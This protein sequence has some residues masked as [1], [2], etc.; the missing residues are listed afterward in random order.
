MASIISS[1]S[2]LIS[3]VPGLK[4]SADTSGALQI[5][6]GNNATAITVDAS[7]NV[8]IGTATPTAK[9]HVT[10]SGV[11]SVP[12][13]SGTT[14]ATGTLI[15]LGTSSDSAGG[16]GTI[17]LSTNQMWIQVTDSTNLAAGNALLL[18]PNGGNV[19]IGISSPTGKLDISATTDGQLMTQVRNLSNGTSAYSAFFMGNDTNATAAYIGLNSSNNTARGGGA[20]S[21]NIINGL[22]GPV[23]FG[24][25][26]TERMRIDSSG[27]VILGYDQATGTQVVKS[28]ATA[29]AVGN[30][31]GEVR[32]GINDGSFGGI[33]IPDVTSTNASY[34]A[35]YIQFHTHQGGVSAG[36]RMRITA[37]GYVGIAT[38]APAAL[39][40][41][42][43]LS[44]GAINGYTKFIIDSSDY[45]VATLKSPA[46]NFSQIIFTDTTTTSLG[47]INYFNSTNATPNA[48]AF[49]TA[50]S[51][52]MRIDSSG[53]V[54]IG[55]FTT[56]IA[57]KFT[58]IGEGNF[59]D[60]SNNTRLYIG[61]GTI[62]GT[63]GGGAYIYNADNTPLAFG[64][65]NTERMRIDTSGNVGIGTTVNN[66]YDQVAAQ[67]PLVVQRS[68]TSTTLNGSTAAIAIVNGDTTTSN[69]AQLN[70]AAITGA[71]TNQ[72]SSAIIACTFGAR[73]NGQYPTGILTFSTSTSLNAAP[74]EKM[75]IESSG[76][77]GI[78]TSSPSASAI[79]DAQSTTK[80]VR[81]PNMTT[82]QKNAISSPAAG[83][84]VF[85]TTLSKLCVYSG[86][87]W[88]TITSV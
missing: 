7:Q 18:N 30:R 26:G 88:Q 66:V 24:V 80:G 68:D 31:G 14:L 61:Y 67:R 87:A 86:A 73:T 50:G 12:A 16:I 44:S 11:A 34:N 33:V 56:S 19:G 82:T 79:L 63:G 52:R 37:D 40:H 13:T 47:G 6:T 4:T 5:Q 29:H 45:A 71:S 28:F 84:M 60:A 69:T 59:T 15:R 2:G 25:S 70:F 83:L 46:A 55:T 22:N 21:L 48:M 58:V 42:G 74:T 77:V 43:P 54:N 65:T 35:Q 85:D 51:E 8:G 20:S 1:D 81:M 72:Y 27:N 64:T 10:T 62:P 23:T 76:N 41:V 17:G 53:N 9:L 39:L 78:G 57:K 38:T 32:F 3:G 75:R 36:E 49:L